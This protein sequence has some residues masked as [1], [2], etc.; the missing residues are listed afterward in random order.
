MGEL[1]L[2]LRQDEFGNLVATANGGE[3]ATIDMQAVF[4]AAA[5]K[6]NQKMPF[7]LSAFDELVKSG[8]SQEVR[9]SGTEKP[10]VFQV[11]EDTAISIYRV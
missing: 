10:A 3:T 1:P 4:K 9:I 11:F 8:F 6:R 7:E 2:F 5:E